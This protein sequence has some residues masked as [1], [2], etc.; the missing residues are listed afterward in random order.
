ME[1]PLLPPVSAGLFR[2]LVFDVCQNRFE[3]REAASTAGQQLSGM[4]KYTTGLEFGQD[5]QS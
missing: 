1:A 2:Y 4:L 3:S 5:A